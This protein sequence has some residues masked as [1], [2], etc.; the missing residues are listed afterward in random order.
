[1]HVSDSGMMLGSVFGSS[2]ESLFM[3]VRLMLLIRVNN[4]DGFYFLAFVPNA[5]SALSDE[6]GLVPLFSNNSWMAEARNTRALV[7]IFVGRRS[8]LEAGT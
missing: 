5:S 2:K 8:F 7:E 3:W 1:M 4:I 6:D